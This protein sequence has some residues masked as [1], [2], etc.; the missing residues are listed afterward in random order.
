MF[1]VVLPSAA[2][3]DR[4]MAAPACPTTATDV[5]SAQRAAQA[6]GGRVEAMSDRTAY[7]QLF[8]TY[9]AAGQTITLSW[10]FGALPAPVVSG[11]SALVENLL[12]YSWGA[13]SAGR[14]VHVFDGG[15]GIGSDAGGS[16]GTSTTHVSGYPHP[17][18]CNA[19]DASGAL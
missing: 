5:A 4:A 13:D 19:V 15:Y 12:G 11:S 10:P 9:R 7:R 17:H 3:L 14:N 1:V 6:C 8:A 18:P 16:G 2:R